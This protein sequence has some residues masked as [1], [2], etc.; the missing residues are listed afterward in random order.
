METVTMNLNATLVG[1][2]AFVLAII[3]ALVGYFLGRRKSNSPILLS[4][5]GFV[6]GLIPPLG[7]VFILVLALKKDLTTNENTVT[8]GRN[9]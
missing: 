9:E 8:S 3:C 2:F 4:V 7:A 1:Q 5:V 6:C